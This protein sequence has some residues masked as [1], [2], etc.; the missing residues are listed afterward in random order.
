M[1]PTEN[2]IVPRAEHSR[3]FTL[4]E[5]LVVIAIIAVLA[6]LLL[7]ALASAKTKSKQTKCLN[8]HKQLVLG[9]Q[10]YADEYD[11][12]YPW[13]SSWSGIGGT[14][15]NTAFY[16]SNAATNGWTNRV[17][18]RYVV[19]PETYRD[20]SDKGESLNGGI[21]NT[22]VA[23]GTSYLF[24]WS[25]NNFRVAKV[26]GNYTAAVNSASYR[27]AR[28][29]DFALKTETKIIEGCWVWHMNRDLVD[30]RNTWH[31]QRGLRGINFAY[32]DGHSQ[33]FRMPDAATNW[34]SAPAPALDWEWW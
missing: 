3:A 23:Y 29:A 25:G 16:N 12:S 11:E 18:N 9:S 7:P 13:S 19:A 10:L 17:L 4:I 28:V 32:A 24:Q 6:G 30:L 21:A 14:N 33:F 31:T 2:S 22:F 27:S 15:G 5:L 20:P 26:A 1:R 34:V 8:N